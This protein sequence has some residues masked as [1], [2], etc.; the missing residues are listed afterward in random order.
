MTSVMWY[1]WQLG[2]D[3]QD[4]CFLRLPQEVFAQEILVCVTGPL[5]LQPPL[6]LKQL[7]MPCYVLWAASSIGLR[8]GVHGLD[9]ANSEQRT[10]P[11][12]GCAEKSMPFEQS[13]GTTFSRPHR[14]FAFQHRNLRE[15][16]KQLVPIKLPEE[17]CIHI[18]DTF[19]NI[20]NEAWVQ[21]SH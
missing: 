7:H 9:A 12:A 10:Q 1:N 14:H 18:C 3:P 6:P 16:R 15:V 8:H 5:H 2:K 21:N 19:S 20:S 4:F 11:L 13:R 17:L